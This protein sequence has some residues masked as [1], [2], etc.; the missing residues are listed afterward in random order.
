MIQ[1]GRLRERP[2]LH[3]RPL[4]HEALSSWMDRLAACCRLKRREFLRLAL[5]VDP[6]PGDGEL[7]AIGALAGLADTFA[8]RTGVSSGCTHGMTLAGYVPDL[9]A[10]SE[11]RPGLFNAY[12]GQFGWFVA[13]SRRSTSRL[14][15]QESWLP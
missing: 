3:P 7:D 8:E 6:A 4:P 9:I 5:G 2:P 15:P 14:E 10:V 12:A 13:P 11:P 1:H